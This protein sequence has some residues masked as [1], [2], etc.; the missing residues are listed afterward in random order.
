MRA[1]HECSDYIDSG[2]RAVRTGTA[3]T[4]LNVAKTQWLH[5][6]AYAVLHRVCFCLWLKVEKYFVFDVPLRGA[7]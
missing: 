1:G 7:L 5:Q 4:D 2:E 3:H 6:S